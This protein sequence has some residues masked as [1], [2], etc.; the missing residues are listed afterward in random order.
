MVP[1]SNV[2]LVRIQKD[3]RGEE[4]VKAETRTNVSRTQTGWNFCPIN[5]VEPLDIPVPYHIYRYS[6]GGYVQILCL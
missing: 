2:A 6:L 4:E 3:L 5:F 1:N